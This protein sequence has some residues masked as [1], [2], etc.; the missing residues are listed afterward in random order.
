MIKQLSWRLLMLAGMMAAGA[1]SAA[2][3]TFTCTGTLPPASSGSW[4]AVNVPMGA[5][6]NVA[7]SGNV[8]VSGPVTV[9]SGATLADFGT[10]TFTAGSLSAV[11]AKTIYLVP[12]AGGAVSI[13]GGASVTRTTSTVDIRDSFIGSTLMVTNSMIS[14]YINLTGNSVGG[15]LLNQSNNTP[16]PGANDIVNN[17][18]GGSL[19]C[20]NN[21]PAPQ[22]GGT[23]NT[24]GGAKTVQCSGL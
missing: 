22:D 24:V 5:T 23:P 9:G 19:I 16:A 1:G 21:S 18:I 12:T 7:G 20:T 14:A 4:T 10:A 2:A 15:S 17:T 11:G 3:Q 6:C 13:L 8:T